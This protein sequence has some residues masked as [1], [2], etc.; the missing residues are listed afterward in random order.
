MVMETVGKIEILFIIHSAQ[1]LVFPSFFLSSL[2]RLPLGLLLVLFSPFFPLASAF[3]V[4]T[5]T[6]QITEAK[7]FMYLLANILQREEK[8]GEALRVC[9]VIVKILEIMFKRRWR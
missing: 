3:L 9:F 7:I 5:I 8:Q 6:T 4:H 2:R 1:V